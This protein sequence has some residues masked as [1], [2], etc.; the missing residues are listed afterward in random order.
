MT[1]R[2]PNTAGAAAAKLRHAGETATGSIPSRPAGQIRRKNDAARSL[3][4]PS[5]ST[6]RRGKIKRG[7]CVYCLST[8]VQPLIR[9]VS[10]PLQSL[11][12][13]CREHVHAERHE[14]ATAARGPTMTVEK[15]THFSDQLAKFDALLDRLSAADRARL[16]VRLTDLSGPMA[17]GV[18]TPL[19]RL[20]LMRAYVSL[21]GEF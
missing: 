6:L 3:G 12:W 18:G 14:I 2:E 13:V 1:G 19:Y 16:D 7:R 15:K 4:R 8:R 20:L 9:D 21:F 5:A 11:V 10:R 17:I